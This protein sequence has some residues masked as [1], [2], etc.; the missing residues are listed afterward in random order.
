MAA[1]MTS[2]RRLRSAV[3]ALAGRSVSDIEAV[4]NALSDDER[5]QLRPLLAEAASTVSGTA[6][7]FM[8]AAPTPLP[9]SAEDAQSDALAPALARLVDHWPDALVVRALE[10]L[11]DTQHAHFLAL[12]PAVRHPAFLRRPPQVA[13]TSHARAALMNAVRHDA[14]AIPAADQQ[15]S[16][17]ATAPLTWRQRFFQRLRKG[18]HS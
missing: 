3:S 17:V 11:D 10:Q 9:A 13:L 6:L 18:Q 8:S 7:D 12:L 16:G 14:N 2:E 4:W 1:S 15:A 5:E